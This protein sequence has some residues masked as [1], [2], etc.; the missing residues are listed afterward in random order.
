MA[1]KTIVGTLLCMVVAMILTFI[2]AG[3]TVQQF[4][5]LGL[6]LSAF[7]TL[8]LL[9]APLTGLSLGSWAGL[10][11]WIAGGFVGGLICRSYGRAIAMAVLSV[12]LAVVLTL[13]LVSLL[14]GVSIVDVLTAMGSSI[15]ALLPDLAVA[16]GLAA[17]GGLIG[18]TITKS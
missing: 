17:V 12:V 16:I 11:A 2:L 9:I 6:Q 4:Q 18:A 13:G 15:T 3:G 7:L 5:A 14:G 10:I 8:M 1:A